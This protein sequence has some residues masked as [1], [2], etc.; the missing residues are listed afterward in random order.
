MSES[1]E[2]CRKRAERKFWIEH[3]RT[4]RQRKEN[5]R[6]MLMPTEELLQEHEANI[7]YGAYAKAEKTRTEI[8]YRI[9]ESAVQSEMNDE[10][11]SKTEGQP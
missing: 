2:E 8:R 10:A 6:I 7:L 11:Q 3:E 4:I 5:L 9:N 1:P